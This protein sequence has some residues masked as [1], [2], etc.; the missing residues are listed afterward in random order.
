MLASNDY[1]EG[2]DIW[3]VG[4]LIGEVLL[5]KPMFPG[6]KVKEMWKKIIYFTGLKKED[7]LGFSEEQQEYIFGMFPDESENHY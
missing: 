4:C 1:T 7:V 5:G 2:V 6:K 3:S